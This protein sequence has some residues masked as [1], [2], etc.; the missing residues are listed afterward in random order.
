[1]FIRVGKVGGVGGAG[2]AGGATP[3]LHFYILLQ[4]VSNY[5][6]DS[7]QFQLLDSQNKELLDNSNN[8]L[9]VGGDTLYFQSEENLNTYLQNNFNT[10]SSLTNYQIQIKNSAGNIFS[11]KN[12]NSSGFAKFDFINFYAN[13]I[14]S[15]TGPD[16]FNK[17]ES[18][19]INNNDCIF[20]LFN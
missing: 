11:I 12:S 6:G 13:I 4:K 9:W 8:N 1:M 16:N 3:G 15:I 7:T 5:K 18:V 2:G 17:E 20:Y 10:D 14:V 19:S